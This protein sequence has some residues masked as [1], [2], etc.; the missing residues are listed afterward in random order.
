MKRMEIG[1]QPFL[2]P[3]CE[4]CV[5]CAFARGITNKAR[6]RRRRSLLLPSSP[7]PV[8][9]VVDPVIA[10]YF[11]SYALINPAGGSICFVDKE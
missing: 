2:L 8:L 11:K 10:H 9:K 6:R 4:L 7:V 3:L 5:L 1:Q